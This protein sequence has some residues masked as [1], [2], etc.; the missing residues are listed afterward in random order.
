[1]S[2]GSG[3]AQCCFPLK[4]M[5]NFRE[6]SAWSPHYLISYYIIFVLFYFCTV[7]YFLI[8]IW[9]EGTAFLVPWRTCHTHSFQALLVPPRTLKL[10]AE[11]PQNNIPVPQDHETKPNPCCRHC[12][13]PDLPIQAFKE[14]I[15]PE[16]GMCETVW[17]HERM[18][19]CKCT[20]K[21]NKN[22]T[23]CMHAEQMLQVW[24]CMS[25][26]CMRIY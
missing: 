9:W 13:F 6:L 8:H 21:D 12:L 19:K 25:D 5:W 22:K 17:M 16:Q 14:E 26:Q 7:D 2:F 23:I 18:R 11:A 10:R 3:W 15:K 1:M 4:L 24:L 20:L